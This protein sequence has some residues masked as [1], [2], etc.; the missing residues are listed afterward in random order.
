MTRGANGVRIMK[1]REDEGNG[2]GAICSGGGAGGS[3]V[4]SGGSAPPQDGGP[5]LSA[6]DGTNPNDVWRLYVVDDTVG[7]AGLISGGW[8]LTI[9]AKVIR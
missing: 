4:A 3:G 7:S 2:R 9:K 8:S 5:A 1:E 6:F